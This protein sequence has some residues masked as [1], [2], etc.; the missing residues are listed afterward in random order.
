MESLHPEPFVT[1]VYCYRNRDLARVKRS[2]DSLCEQTIKNF[3]VLF[4]DYGSDA[5]V[6]IEIQKIISKYSFCKYV[7]NDTGGMFWNR[8]HALNTGIRLAATEFVF[9]ADID[10]IFKKNFV[11]KLLQEAGIDCVSFFQVYYLPEKFSNWENMGSSTYETSKKFALG[12]ALIP[13]KIVSAIGG[14]D[15]FYCFWGLEDNDLEHRLNTAG[16][17]T[18]FYDE[19]V[20]M[21]HQWHAPSISS[22]KDYPTGWGVF[23][24][25]YFNS[26]KTIVKRNEDREWGK[27]FSRKERASIKIMND[28]STKFDACNG[29]AAFFMY[30]LMMQFKKMK[31]GEHSA[32]EFNDVNSAMHLH[33]RLGK[34]ISLLQKFFNAAKIPVKAVSPFRHLYATINEVRD[35]MM[36]FILAHSDQIEDYSI[37]IDEKKLKVVIFKK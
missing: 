23:Q 33:S 11:E 9:T 19:E 5:E 35:A 31:P 34:T 36:I 29:S 27:L 6:Q 26:K 17:K 3:T 13:V 2:L 22:E 8:S 25:D 28:P 10:M 14:Y 18:K 4:V 1:I 15:E 37:F 24:N 32:F 16:V 20:L 12:L 7:Y 21:Y 30:Q